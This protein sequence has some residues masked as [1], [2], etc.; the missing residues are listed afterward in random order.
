M[1]KITIHELASSLQTR[2]DNQEENKQ[3]KTDNNLQTINKTIVGAINELAQSSS[4]DTN[5]QDKTDDSLKTTDKT[6][7]GA[8][9]EVFQKTNSAVNNA[10]N[11]TAN[12]QDKTDDNL[13]TADKTI[14]GAINEVFQSANNGK[15]L[16]ADAI[17]A[18]LSP[19]QT[20]S[21][22]SEDI[23]SMLTTFKNNMI[24]KGASV[25][26][27]DK[28][29]QLISKIPELSGDG[30]HNNV[31]IQYASETLDV[32]F[33]QMNALSGT[34]STIL[35]E[36]DF[37]PKFVM[38][39]T[40]NYSGKYISI[41]SNYHKYI[42]PE[43][44]GTSEPPYGIIDTTF[45]GRQLYISVVLEGKKIR[46]DYKTSFSPLDYTLPITYYA[47]G[48]GKNSALDDTEEN[49]NYEY[50][51][52]IFMQPDQP[53]AQNYGD[54][55][56]PVSTSDYKLNFA[57]DTLDILYPTD[58]DI[59]IK[60]ANSYIQF[61][62]D[63]SFNTF[64]TS[65]VTSF[66]INL[67]TNTKQEGAGSCNIH[68]LENAVSSVFVKLGAVKTYD[69][70]TGI[71]TKTN[72]K[73]WNGSM[74]MGFT[75]EDVIAYA[76]IDISYRTNI[77]AIDLESQSLIWSYLGDAICDE[78][79]SY[80]GEH[81][82]ITE[83]NETLLVQIADELTSGYSFLCFFDKKTGELKNKKKF[84][85]YSINYDGHSVYCKDN[86]FIHLY[87]NSYDYSYTLYK[88]DEDGNQITSLYYP[89]NN[90]NPDADA[91]ILFDD[92][93]GVSGYRWDEF[94][95]HS[96]DFSKSI[97]F[98][99]EYD[100]DD[101]LAYTGSF[102]KL[103]EYMSF[104]YSSE[105]RTFTQYIM[106]VDIESG[107]RNI[108]KGINLIIPDSFKTTSMGT[109]R[110]FIHRETGEE[111]FVYYK[112][113][114]SDDDYS[115]IAVYDG[116]GNLVYSSTTLPRYLYNSVVYEGGLLIGA[117]YSDYGKLFRFDLQD[118]TY[119]TLYTLPDATSK[120]TGLITS[121]G[122]VGKNNENYGI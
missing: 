93:I 45:N 13:Q 20:F 120:Y 57:K 101:V 43:Y 32:D 56:I 82:E 38:L 89:N 76:A 60:V 46:L 39:E 28:F 64:L 87:S 100:G 73:F 22:M 94:I 69:T 17:G 4:S 23:N 84:S 106:T 92:C 109:P 50:N 90:V 16:I 99:D 81:F 10:T 25:G 110:S 1:G 62:L 51:I 65:D 12:K 44:I 77:V 33:V 71:W 67:F 105:S 37:T 121:S 31:G 78:T 18:P 107:T 83:G 119:K 117:N 5:K 52:K 55:W 75:D 79:F 96:F 8:I 116:V 58:K 34:F 30:E 35:K 11:N 74:W 80:V 21:A 24:N 68:L 66:N 53:T 91:L 104:I 54:I 14:V 9:N 6:I 27:D 36:L 2:L 7:V 118:Y 48:E 63:E 115:E 85:K 114:S 29:K 112:T 47:I 95:I 70:S 40:K 103:G 122:L 15:Q 49:S 59:Y 111:M 42:N 113:A 72:S 88:Y 3:D 61:R 86:T 41:N 102:T 26:N 97:E 108:K 19:T 98:S